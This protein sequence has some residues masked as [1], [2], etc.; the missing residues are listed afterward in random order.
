MEIVFFLTEFD[1]LELQHG[2]PLR[3]AFL[4]TTYCQDSGV[5]TETIV[6]MTSTEG[7]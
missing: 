3:Y 2:R 4:K 6:L 5:D 7:T 1:H